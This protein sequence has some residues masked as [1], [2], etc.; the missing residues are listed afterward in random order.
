[1]ILSFLTIGLNAIR[2]LQPS[3]FS[4][5]GFSVKDVFQ[6]LRE[7]GVPQYCQN[8]SD[9]ERGFSFTEDRTCGGIKKPL[10]AKVGE[11][12]QKLQGIELTVGKYN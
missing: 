6:K 5:N 2:I 12:R 7:M 1:M 3:Y 4:Y 9:Y 11:L 10:E 8:L